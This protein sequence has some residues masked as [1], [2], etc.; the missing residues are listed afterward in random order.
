MNDWGIRSRV[1][2]LA[3]IPTGLVALVMGAYFVAARIQD[4]N[5]NVQDR[6][7]TIANYLAQ[8]SEYSLLSRNSR[9]LSRLVTSARDGDD[10][11]LAIAIFAK[12]NLL[13]SS[14]GTKELVSQLSQTANKPLLQTSINKNNNGFIVRAP[15]VSQPTITKR[16]NNSAISDLPVIGY[17]AV[18]ITNKNIQLRQYQTLATAFVILLI[19]LILGGILAQN[20]AR[21]ITIP[22]IQLANAVKR[23]K[24]GQLKVA[25][26]AKTSGE[27]RTLVDGFN[28][29]SDS[30]YEAREEMQMAI[31]QATADINAT[32]TSLEEQNVELNMARKEAVEASRVKSEF[33]ANMSHEIR[34]PMNGVIGFTNL[35]LRSKLTKKQKDY[36]S[37][38]KKSANGLLSIIDNILD[39]SKIEAGKME[40]EKRSFCIGDC[41][42]ETL[43]L[44]APAAQAK[45]IEILGIVYQDVPELLLG[46][47]GRIGQILTNLCNNAIKF[48]EQGTIQIRVMLEE[49]NNTSVRLRINISDTGVGL[50]EDQQKVLFQA[51]TQADTTTT[52]RFGGTGLG[53]VIS[54]KLAESMK[55]KIGLESKENV[56]STF[57][58]TLELDKDLQTVAK[59]SLGFP[60]RRVLFH[61]TNNVSQLATKYLL[62]RWDTLVES[63]DN[64]TDLIAMAEIYQKQNKDIHLILIGGCQPENNK[65][66]LLALKEISDKL[67]TPMA[68]LINSKEEK[69]IQ[70]YANLGLTRYLSKPV[71]KEPFYDALMHWFNI[72]NQQ[73]NDNKPQINQPVAPSKIHI[74]CVDDN[75]ANLKLIDAFL[76]DFSVETQLA[77]SGLQAVERC[78]DT[79]FHLIFMDIQMPDMDGLEATQVI[80]RISPFYKSSPIIALT[81]HA[82]KGEKDRLLQEGMDDYLTKP[83]SQNQLQE[84]ILKWTNKNVSMKLDINTLNDSNSSNVLELSIDWQ[85]SLKNAGGKDDLA[86]DMLKMLVAS[87]PEARELIQE[88]LDSGDIQE[89]TAQ[90]HKLHGATAYCGVPE[91]KSLA[92]QYESLLKT[93]GIDQLL[94]ALHIKFLDELERVKNDAGMILD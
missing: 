60:G 48:T 87:F 65:K 63:S 53:L 1:I 59:S 57:W 30:L 61:D 41:V 51:F 33:L 91:L 92:N 4:L 18:L 23:I 22:I 77:S 9:T 2:L 62:G 76:S 81:A 15:I 52:R 94:H 75:Q 5:V 70:Q 73:L 31:E 42:D 32:A 80:R 25:I 43:N 29:M 56:G 28:D 82:M 40:F 83:I 36:L 21:N 66:E 17:V 39:F 37:T 74:L 79:E 19:G 35:L 26:K 38:I 45:N 47:A 27:L 86:R 54:K 12:N 85:L 3:I 7:M 71:T 72:D 89:L 69:N 14:S 93:S 24:E 44:L 64:L 67:N 20:M 34:T 90:V 50:S 49:E 88:N 68:V 13:L 84:S 10:D 78:K 46:D 58:F 16:N 6:G 8:T 11:I 55:G